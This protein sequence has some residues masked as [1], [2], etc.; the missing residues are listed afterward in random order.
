MTTKADLYRAQA[1]S[2]AGHEYQWGEEPIYDLDPD[3]NPDD[4]DCSGTAWAL[5]KF[6]G[7]SLPRLTAEGFRRRGIKI[8]APSMVGADFFCLL[9]SD[10]TAHH[11]GVFIGLGQTFEARGE[12][13]GMVKSTVTAVNS[14]G[15]KWYRM[16]GVNLGS[17]SVT[18]APVIAPLTPPVAWSGNVVSNTWWARSH[19]DARVFRWQARMRVRGWTIG[20]DGKYGPQSAAVAH[21]FQLEKRLTVDGKLGKQTYDAAWTMAVTK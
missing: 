19:Y 11:I 7:V 4:G 13:Y 2:M 1:L 9:R 18:A 17:L 6:A 5:W 10:G 21:A 12:A 15:A 8:A 20:V 3:S 14:R 16:P